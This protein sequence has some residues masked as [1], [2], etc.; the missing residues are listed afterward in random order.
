MLRRMGET[1]SQILSS[2]RLF[3][4]CASGTGCW[5]VSFLTLLWDLI[6]CWWLVHWLSSFSY[7]WCCEQN[8]INSLLAG[9]YLSHLGYVIH[10]K[11]IIYV[12]HEKYRICIRIKGG[13]ELDS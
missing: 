11:Q 9:K 3:S 1:T 2:V 10:E 8:F 6:T 12:Y 7:N 5:L 13:E 4:I